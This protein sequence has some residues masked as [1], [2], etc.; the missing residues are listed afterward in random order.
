MVT[1]GHL[2]HNEH[3]SGLLAAPNSQVTGA[4]G[5]GS[6]GGKISGLGAGYQMRYQIQASKRVS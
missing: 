4:A 6:G 5:G 2:L 3:P 1:V